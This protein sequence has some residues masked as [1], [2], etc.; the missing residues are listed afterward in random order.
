MGASLSSLAS[1]LPWVTCDPL[2]VPSLGCVC[3]ARFWPCCGA[4]PV[5]PGCASLKPPHFSYPISPKETMS[6]K[7]DPMPDRMA[8][9]KPRRLH[10]LPLHQTEKHNLLSEPR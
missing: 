5:E 1:G 2:W 8:H 9:E 6:L 10:L 7:Y 4:G 3:L